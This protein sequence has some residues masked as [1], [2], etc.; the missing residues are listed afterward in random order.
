M[1]FNTDTTNAVSDIFSVYD[2][3]GE[4]HFFGVSQI[5]GIFINPPRLLPTDL[6]VQLN[7][8]KLL[9]IR[10]FWRGNWSFESSWLV[11]E[12]IPRTRNFAWVKDYLSQT[13]VEGRFDVFL[14]AVYPTQEPFKPHN[15]NW[16]WTFV[17]LQ[18][19]GMM[20]WAL[21]GDGRE[22]FKS[23]QKDDGAPSL[24]LDAAL[25]LCVPVCD[26][27]ISFIGFV[28]VAWFL[29]GSRTRDTSQ[30]CV[31]YKCCCNISPT[32]Q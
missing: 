30:R 19:T 29:R 11:M 22:G 20:K 24:T 17:Y 25:R 15:A 14:R 23:F 13:Q 7:P 27:G 4:I 16:L 10:G 1:S 9:M 3:M 2:D 21:A 12:H 18:S 6:L 28:I 32:L 5:Q 8:D 31:F 26:S